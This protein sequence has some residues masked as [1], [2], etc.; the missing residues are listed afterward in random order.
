[1]IN[2]TGLMHCP[3]IGVAVGSTGCLD[4]GSGMQIGVNTG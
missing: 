4:G 3:F 1:M 2:Y